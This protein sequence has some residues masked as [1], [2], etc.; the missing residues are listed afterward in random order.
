MFGELASWAQN[1]WPKLFNDWPCTPS[2][3]IEITIVEPESSID[4][5]GLPNSLERCHGRIFDLHEQIKGLEE[6][7]KAA[8]LEIERLRP[9]A[10]LGRKHRDRYK[11]NA[12]KPRNSRDSLA[13]AEPIN[14][15]RPMR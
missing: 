7:L 10:E 14:R 12:R 5:V 13:R 2:V 9:D 11:A 8:Q 1:T 4:V 15:A 3:E 6:S